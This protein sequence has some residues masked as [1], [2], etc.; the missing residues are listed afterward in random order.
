M[1]ISFFIFQKNCLMLKSA[2]L[3]ETV[4]CVTSSAG[5]AYKAEWVY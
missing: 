5:M 1:S 4:F 3:H 2:D